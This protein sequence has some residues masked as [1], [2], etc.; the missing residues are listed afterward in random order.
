MEIYYMKLLFNLKYKYVHILYRY[1]K[2]IKYLYN[3]YI[4]KY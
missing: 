3:F 1:Y 4:G 2:L